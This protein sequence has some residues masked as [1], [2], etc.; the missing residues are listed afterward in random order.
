MNPGFHLSLSWWM[1]RFTSFSAGL[2]FVS[3]RIVF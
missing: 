3:S 2:N 1:S